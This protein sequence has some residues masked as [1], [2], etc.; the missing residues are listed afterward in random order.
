MG[1]RKYRPTT[2]GRRGSSVADFVEITRSEPEKSLVRPLSKTGGRNNHGRVTTRHKGGGH[3]HRYRTVDFLRNKDGVAGKVE[4]L[5]GR[6]RLAR[7]DVLVEGVE[8]RVREGRAQVVADDGAVFT[9][10]HPAGSVS[11]AAQQVFQIR[12]GGVRQPQEHALGRRVGFPAAA[13]RRR[14]GSGLGR[15]S[16]RIISRV[17]AQR[18]RRA[19]ALCGLEASSMHDST[20]RTAW[21]TRLSM[22]K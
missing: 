2:P 14:A 21:A 6:Y 18:S 3:R 20:L 15:L 22:I 19:T 8:D 1:I 12:L 17:A 4:R 16:I 10:L 11:I 5:E 13:N 9:H 7:T